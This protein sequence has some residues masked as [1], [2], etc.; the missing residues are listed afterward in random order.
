VS[1]YLNTGRVEATSALTVTGLNR[2]LAFGADSRSRS[3]FALSLSVAVFG[4]Q[5]LPWEGT[6]TA[7]QTTTP[8]AL[9]TS[10]RPLPIQPSASLELVGRLLSHSCGFCFDVYER[11]PGESGDLLYV[12]AEAE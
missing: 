10:P 8:V 6:M 7:E 12:H 5:T 1:S 4:A 3:H 9:T 2:Y 11:P